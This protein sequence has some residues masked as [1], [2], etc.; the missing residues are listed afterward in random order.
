MKILGSMRSPSSAISYRS[1]STRELGVRMLTMHGHAEEDD[2]DDDVDDGED[3]DDVD[4]DG[5]DPVPVPPGVPRNSIK[6]TMH[7]NLMVCIPNGAI[8]S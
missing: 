7:L 4:D 2:D 1:R 5:L 6:S 3:G 8:R